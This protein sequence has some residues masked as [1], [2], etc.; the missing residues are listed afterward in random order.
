MSISYFASSEP[1]LAALGKPQDIRV[2]PGFKQGTIPQNVLHRLDNTHGIKF[3][4]AHGDAYSTL[5]RSPGICFAATVIVQLG[6][7]SARRSAVVKPETPAL[8]KV[9]QLGALV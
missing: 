6:T 7:C 1:F 3:A 4:P 8:S 9:C 5:S 2:Y